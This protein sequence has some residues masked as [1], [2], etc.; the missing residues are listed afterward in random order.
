[1]TQN[2]I[3]SLRV[4]GLGMIGIFIVAIVLMLIMMILTKVFPGDKN[5]TTENGEQH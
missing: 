1:M 2:F 4:M 5:D 3:A